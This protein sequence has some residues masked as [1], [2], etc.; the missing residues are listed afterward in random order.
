M[1]WFKH[2]NTFNNPKVE[3]LTEK[4]G[5]EGYGVYFRIVELISTNI[6]P[7][8]VQEWGFLPSEYDEEYLSKKLG[9]TT[10]K[11]RSIL[12][13]CLRLNLLQKSKET[14]MCS[15]ILERADDYTQR[16]INKTTNKVRSISEQSSSRIEE[17]RIDKNRIEKRENTVSYLLTLNDEDIKELTST[18]KVNLIQLKEKAESLHNYCKSH[19]KIYKNYRALLINALARDFGKKPAPFVSLIDKLKEGGEHAIIS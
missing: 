10:E 6:E 9:V 3:R 7:D 16:I 19:G 8:N 5:S 4:F 14:I 17:K 15:Q 2:E 11:L 1:K 12:E 13:E 18:Y